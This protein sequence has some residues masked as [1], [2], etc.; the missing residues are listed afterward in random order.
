VIEVPK[1]LT[2]RLDAPAK[3][4]HGTGHVKWV[5][6]FCFLLALFFGHPPRAQS[7]FSFLGAPYISREGAALVLN[8]ES[9][10]GELDGAEPSSTRGS[11]F[12]VTG[13]GGGGCI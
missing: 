13:S 7:F 8:S 11:D 9:S 3:K 10:C 12:I 1:A 6:F 4:L 5:I 2:W